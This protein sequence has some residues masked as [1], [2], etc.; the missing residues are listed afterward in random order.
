MSEVR[1][2]VAVMTHPSRLAM[3]T[4]L[5][6]SLEE[7]PSVAVDP[8]PDG[9]PSPLR[10]AIP[11]WDAVP[12]RATHHLVL[13]DDVLPAPGFLE[14]VRAGAAAHP[15][16][17]LAFYT[18]WFSWNGARTRI[19][20]R[21][22]RAWCELVRGEFVPTVALLL[23]R[24]RAREFA[25]FARAAPAH[26]MDDEAMALYVGRRRLPAY[27]RVPNPVEHAGAPSLVAGQ[28]HIGAHRSAC[29]LAAAG[30]LRA[31]GTLRV[32]DV[33]FLPHLSLGEVASVTETAPG[34]WNDIHW[35]D[36]C[37]GLGLSEELLWERCAVA[38]A[39]APPA[40]REAAGGACGRLLS[41]LW[42]A[43]YLEG[44]VSAAVAGGEPDPEVSRRATDALVLGGLAGRLPQPVLRQH[45]DAL[46]GFADAGI[47]AGWRAPRGEPAR[48][49]PAWWL[50]RLR[51]RGS[52][53]P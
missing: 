23:P 29:F 41:S 15:E 1:V 3:A 24:S 18:H 31:H 2:S 7:V 6:R 21:A 28:A 47:A 19:A 39:S 4:A 48:L 43:A 17:A 9:P 49:V 11:A 42:I 22:G 14:I 12:E 38:L 33:P 51:R 25:R 46:A 27:V 36:G 16:A 5:A 32:S 20:A 35:L 53:E 44:A 40:A 13:Q 8:E 26:L 30:C 10:S 50:Q 45:L 34:F 37:L 52:V